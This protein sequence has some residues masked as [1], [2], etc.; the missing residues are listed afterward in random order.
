MLILISVAI[1]GGLSSGKSTVCG[2]FK[3]CGACVVSADE[4][5]H[6]L[7]TPNTP[8][9][10]QVINLLG[11][12]ILTHQNIDRKKI[13]KK[14]FTNPAL[15]GQ[16]EKIL[17]P[18]VLNEIDKRHKQVS[19]RQE[20]SLFVAE[21]PLLYESESHTFFDFVITVVADEKLSKKRFKEATGHPETEY[22]LRM[23]R[24]M[25]PS[26]KAAKADFVI[27]NNGSLEDL[28]TQVLEIYSQ[29]TKGK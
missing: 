1:T 14:V 4:I 25:K 26:E 23:G 12:E 27:Q 18:A 16:L 28:K 20:F 2:L 11:P 15:L 21:I 22:E 6:Q 19:N 8:V 7:L 29:I 10:Q 5:V 13:G 3:A 9:G 17:H 24:Q